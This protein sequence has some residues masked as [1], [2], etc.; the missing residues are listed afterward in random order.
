MSSTPDEPTTSDEDR[1]ALRELARERV[2]GLPGENALG[3]ADPDAGVDVDP[4][5]Y[6]GDHNGCASISRVARVVTP[7]A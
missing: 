1:E 5:T 7:R 6:E 2:E 3:G 4:A